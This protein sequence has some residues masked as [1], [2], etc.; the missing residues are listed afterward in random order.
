[1]AW[2]SEGVL[3]EVVMPGSGGVG[4]SAVGVEP[5][6][7]VGERERGREANCSHASSPRLQS[8]H[9]YLT[10]PRLNT[11]RWLIWKQCVW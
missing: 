3:S 1:M 2:A 5:T 6:M 7:S 4:T 11:W 10:W 9:D 8:N